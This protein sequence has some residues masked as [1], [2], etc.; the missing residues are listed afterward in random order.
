VIYLPLALDIANERTREAKHIA[1]MASARSASP[2]GKPDD[3]RRPNRARQLI[4]LPVRALSD[5][6][7]ALSEVACVAASRIEGAAH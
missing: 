6:S 4:A 3:P 2:A 7:H 1:L 5:A